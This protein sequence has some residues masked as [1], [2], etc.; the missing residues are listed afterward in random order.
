MDRWAGLLTVQ[1]KRRGRLSLKARLNDKERLDEIP[2]AQRMLYRPTLPTLFNNTKN[3]DERGCL[4]HAA[5]MVHGYTLSE[6]A[7]HV[8]LHYATVSKI[9]KRVNEQK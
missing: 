1:V 4:I 8:G 6:I 3:K 2:R 9:V 7:K 5:H